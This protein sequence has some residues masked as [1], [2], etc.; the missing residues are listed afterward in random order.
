[1]AGVLEGIRILDFGRYV[2]GPY[3]ATLLGDLG[4]EVI[5]IERPEG[6]KTAICR[7]LVPTKAPRF[8]LL[9][10]ETNQA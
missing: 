8:F 3:C 4:A 9:S 7:P 10:A 1:M 5:R 6:G 2:A